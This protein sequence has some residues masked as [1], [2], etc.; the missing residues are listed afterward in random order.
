MKMQR[1]EL[2]GAVPP[3]GVSHVS[4][5]PEIDSLE[6]HAQK[7]SIVK[8]TIQVGGSTLL[9]RL[10][11]LAREILMVKF[12]GAGIIS[13]AFFTAYKIPNSL[14][15]IFAEGALSAAFI[16]MLV[17]LS[18]KKDNCAINSLMTISFLIFEG[19]LLGVCALIFFN[20]ETVI[21]II[22]PGWFSGSI[23]PDS[24]LAH[25][26]AYFAP[27]WYSTVASSQVAYAAACLKI[28]ISFIIF[29]SSS[30]LLAGALQT[31]HH[32]FV[33][34]LCSV[35][36]NIVF[37]SGIAICMWLKLSVNAL[38]YFIIFGGLL[39]FLLHIGTYF[40]FNFS[41]ARINKTAWTHFKQVMFTFIPCL[42]S[43]SINEI[44]LFVST[45]LASYLPHG[46]M[47]LIYYAN[48]FMGIPLGVFSTAFSTILLPYFS[49]IHIEAPQRLGFYLY[50]SAKVIFWV[51]V[52]SMTVMMFLSEKIFQ[53]MFL[54]DRF[55]AH[56]V[57]QASYILIA[58]LSGLFFFSLNK[59]ML[60]IFY[61][62]QDK[63]TPSLV[64]LLSA[65]FNYSMSSMLL[66]L[67][68]ATGLA[69]AIVSSSILQTVLFAISLYRI[70]HFTF[71]AREFLQFASRA[72]VQIA[73]LSG[74]FV[75]AYYVATWSIVWLCPSS[76]IDFM[77]YKIGFWLWAG[78]LCLVMGIALV[79]TRKIFRVNLYF[80]D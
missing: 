8:K 72:G 57:A 49:R 13:D 76:A 24:Q 14:R 79:K 10:L 18:K 77:L 3:L 20:A 67:Y 62:R 26:I 51:T 53:T 43:M 64:S 17:A 35:L 54:S 63:V 7:S 21:R 15:K 1:N 73:S 29:L 45:S 52:S 59:I 56:H 39:Q 4:S 78:P 6:E 16:P 12:L 66:P 30:A 70:P 74:I 42:F 23:I 44:N 75:V 5:K 33:P 65:L 41:F 28:V 11:G 34:A 19:I 50:E 61:S 47:S 9:S 68:G 58:F 36:L 27:A 60:N 48:R 31:A 25:T 2:Q 71:Y 32:F 69:L 38:C 37:I 55:T 46:S 40:R 22:A 80:L